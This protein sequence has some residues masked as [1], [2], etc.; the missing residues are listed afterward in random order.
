MRGQKVEEKW[1]QYYKIEE[2]K[3]LQNIEI[4]L[5]DEF[6]KV[7]EELHIEY[8][9]YGGT[10]LGAVKFNGMIPWDDDI[11]VALPRESYEIFCEKA[12]GYLSKDYYLQTPYNT[13]NSPYP[14]AKMRRKGTKYVEYINRNI[15]I[16]T[17][18]YIDIYPIDR[19]PDDEKKRKKQFNNVRTWI[20]IYV[21]RQCRLYD[22]NEKAIKGKIKNAIRYLVC[23]LCHVFSS[24]YIMKK[25]NYYMTMYN[26]TDTKRYA[27]LNSP[28][29]NNIYEQLYPL[30]KIVF[31]GKR[32]NVP[33]DYK[34]HL[35][36]RYGDYSSLP[37]ENERIGHIPY[38]LDLG[39]IENK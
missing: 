23:L 25:I 13:P 8:V 37:P 31:E 36:K 14:Y 2:L 30:K 4:E 6:V 39:D 19:I 1:K 12:S 11:D 10:L 20:L 38:I 22:R 33:G 27:A 17:G 15:D 34:N 32:V 3:K 28:N 35:Y 26:S 24:K 16:D 18:V 21:F 9:L 29:Y 5:L 7:C